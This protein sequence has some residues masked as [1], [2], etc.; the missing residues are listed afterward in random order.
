MYARRVI[1]WVNKEE[2][3]KEG[4]NKISNRGMIKVSGLSHKREKKSDT[5][6]AWL[7]FQKIYLIYSDIKNKK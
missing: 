5:S 3:G 4:Q 7:M 1:Q 2:G 6:I